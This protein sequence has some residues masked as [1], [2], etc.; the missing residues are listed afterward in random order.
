M[1]ARAFF[2]TPKGQLLIL[3]APIVAAAV[4]QSGARSLGELAIAVGVAALIDAP[5]LRRR[6]ERW[7]FPSGAVL[8]GL[9]I[10]MIL[11]PHEAWHVVA[12]ASA[13]AILSKYVVRTASAN[14]FNPAAL[15]LLMAFVLFGA[16]ESW[17]GALPDLPMIALVL[18]GACGVYLADRLGKMPAVVAFLL[19]YFAGFTLASYAGDPLR[20]WEVFRTPDLHAVVFLAFF[21]VTD[22]PTSPPRAREQLVFGAVCALVTIAT[23]LWGGGA[24]FLLTGVLAG[25]VMEA[26]RRIWH[27]RHL[28]ARRAA[29][30]A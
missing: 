15:A 13:G 28:E 7:I 29:H 9:I 6:E 30:Q 19:T 21:M 25:N 16:E 11:S 2:R 27:R 23:Y 8:T 22:P 10:G 26:G 4:W 14:V 5:I 18:V 1:T 20:V 17:W 12:I 24:Y 3:F